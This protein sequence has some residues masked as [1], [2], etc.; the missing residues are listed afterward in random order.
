VKPIL[1][2][3]FSL[4]SVSLGKDSWIGADKAKHFFL[5][6]FV[7]S[8]AFSGLRSATVGKSAALTGAS[9]VTSAVVVGKEFRDM[10]G[11][12]DPSIKDAVAGLAGAAAVSAALARTK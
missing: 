1:L 4:H 6:A 7:Q 10:R 5:G 11:R 2:I 8:A 3:A 9:A 12:G